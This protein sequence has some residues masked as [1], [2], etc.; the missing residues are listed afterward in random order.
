VIYLD[1]SAFL[2]LY[3][4]EDGSQDVARLVES[5]DEPLPVWDMLEAELINALRLKTFWGDISTE[6]ADQQIKLFDVRKRRGLYIVPELARGDLMVSFRRLAAETAC[7]G[8]RTMDIIHVACAMQLNA[9]AF[10]SY[11]KRQR[12]LAKHAGLSVWGTR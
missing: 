10:L 5:Q 2:K 12:T 4:L 6:Q 1:T 9:T 8:C 11:D 7:L 3:I